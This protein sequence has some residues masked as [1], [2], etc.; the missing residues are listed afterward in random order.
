MYN[1]SAYILGKIR[2]RSDYYLVLEIWSYDELMAC[3]TT[4]NGCIGD[5]KWPS[6]SYSTDSDCKS[7][8]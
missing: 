6:F 5:H 3:D 8:E 1:S 4:K 7:V 2:Q